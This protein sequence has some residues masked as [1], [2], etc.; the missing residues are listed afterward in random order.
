MGPLEPLIPAVFLT[1][2]TPCDKLAVVTLA[3][4]IEVRVGEVV[5]I[6]EEDVTTGTILSRHGRAVHYVP[7]DSKVPVDLRTCATSFD[8]ACTPRDDVSEFAVDTMANFAGSLGLA[9][10]CDLVGVLDTL[11]RRKEGRQVWHRK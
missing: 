7:F 4:S 2:R 9:K 1:A 8:V 3:Q 6:R 11:C 5:R 10:T